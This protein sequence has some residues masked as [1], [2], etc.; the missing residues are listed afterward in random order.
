[1]MEQMLS[2]IGKTFPLQELDAGEFKHLKVN[3][4]KFTIR[5]FEA[6][7]LGHVSTMQAKGFFGLMQMDTLIINPKYVDLPLLSYDRVLAAGND[8][9]IFEL[10]DTQESPCDLSAV[11][12]VKQ[13]AAT[14]PTHDLGEHWYDPIKLPQSLSVKGKKP[15]RIAFD[16]T[17]KDYLSA[18]LH[19]AAQAAPCNPAAK[20]DKASVYVNGLLTH[21]GPSTDVFKKALGDEKTTALFRHILFGTKI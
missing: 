15:H 19:S 12:E 16:Q 20:M 6:E 5:A 14:L 1:M 3:G 8:T 2:Q 4:M 7:G 18:F 11:D 13:N 9:L 10:Y 21:G 17:A